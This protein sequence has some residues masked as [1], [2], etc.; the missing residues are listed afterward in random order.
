MKRRQLFKFAASSAVGFSGGIVPPRYLMSVADSSTSNQYGP[1]PLQNKLLDRLKDEPGSWSVEASWLGEDQ[2]LVEINPGQ[3]MKS[4]SLW[5]LTPLLDSYSRRANL[6]L[7]FDDPIVITKSIFERS[8]SPEKFNPGDIITVAQAIQSMIV[9]SNNISAIALGDRLGW[10]QMD[11]NMRAF[12]LTQS[13]VNLRYTTS[14]AR[15]IRKL[16]TFIA[17][18]KTVS[19]NNRI[20][21]RHYREMCSL[22]IRAKPN[23]RIAAGIPNDVP[24]AHKTGDL[25]GVV[26]D[27]GI[28]F[29]PQAPFSLV[30]LSNDVPNRMVA[31]SV[32]IDITKIVYGELLKAEPPN[33]SHTHLHGIQPAAIAKEH[34]TTPPESY[35]PPAWIDSWLKQTT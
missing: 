18:Y 1:K 11:D 2:P 21:D 10:Q 14:T 29:L 8:V 24:V 7:A 3:I 13:K 12:G 32:I 31:E 16:L 22:L 23:Q 33:A 15:D 6:E 25:V 28:V 4:A 19:T 17:G 26:N 34:P 20:I 27:A 9:T 30:V 35:P 5:K